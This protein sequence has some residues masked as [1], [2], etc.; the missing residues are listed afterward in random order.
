MG[1]RDLAVDLDTAMHLSLKLF[2]AAQFVWR[3]AISVEENNKDR[4]III[5]N[6]E[7]EPV[8]IKP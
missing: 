1:E 7:P 4:D 8:K 5:T 6:A 3:D 2:F